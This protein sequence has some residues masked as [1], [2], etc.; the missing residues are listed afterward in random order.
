MRKTIFAIACAVVIV[1]SAT[2]A[3][4]DLLLSPSSPTPPLVTIGP[5]GGTSESGILS[6]IK[7]TLGYD[8]SNELYKQNYQGTESGPFKDSYTTTFN[9]DAS[10]AS[11][12][13][14][15]SQPYINAS[16]AYLIVKDGNHD[17]IW[18]LYDISKPPATQWDGKE[19]IQLSGFWPSRG[20]ISNVGI[21]GTSTSVPDGG[22]T[23][24]L[25]GGALVGLETLRRRFSA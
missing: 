7:D 16:P 17:P 9:S 24:M 12:T 1:L 14:V 21:Y 20:N 8:V 4:A 25:L 13:W 10:G 15:P 3:K 2:T 18:Y 22:M 23:V 5:G 11:I 19:T 6:Y